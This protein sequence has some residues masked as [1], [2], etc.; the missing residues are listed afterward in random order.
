MTGKNGT[1]TKM[2]AGGMA[3]LLVAAVLGTYT[4]A[5]RL[6]SLEATLALYMLT[7]NERHQKLAERVR[8]LERD[9]RGPQ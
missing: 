7:D 4:V 9:W 6:S 3:T 2:L 5:S 1:V 8:D